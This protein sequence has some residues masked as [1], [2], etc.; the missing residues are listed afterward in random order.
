MMRDD[1]HV[2]MVQRGIVIVEMDAL[3]IHMCWYQD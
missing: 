3:V 1:C 2:H